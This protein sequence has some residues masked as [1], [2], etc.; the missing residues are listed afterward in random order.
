MSALRAGRRSAETAAPVSLRAVVLSAAFSC[1]ATAACRSADVRP[2]AGSGDA[3]DAGAV[4]ACA[5]S[6]DAPIRR[7]T[8]WEYEATANAVLGTDERVA[9][10]LPESAGAVF[11]T[12]VEAQVASGV[13]VEGLDAAAERLALAA[14]LGAL[15][16]CGVSDEC[17]PRFVAAVGARAFR[18]SLTAAELE[19]F[20]ALYATLRRDDATDAAYRGVLQALLQ[21]P[22]FVFRPERAASSGLRPLSGAEV[23]TR[24]AFFLWGQ[25][26]DAALLAAAAR[27]ELDDKPGVARWAGLLLDDPRARAQVARF[28]VEWLGVGALAHAAKDDPRFEGLR[29]SL[30]EEVRRFGTW[31]TLDDRHFSELFRARRSFLNA[32]LGALYGL[33]VESDGTFHDT[34]LQ[35]TQRQGVLTLPGVLAAWAKVDQS[36]PVQR[37]RLVRERI[38][39]EVLPSPPPNVVAVLPP[40]TSGTTRQRLAAHVA[41]EACAGCHRLIDPVG[42]LFENYDAVGGYRAVENQLPVDARGEVP[43]HAELTGKY[44]GVLE[45]E[46]ALAG[47]QA[48]RRCL[49]TQWL[50]FARGRQERPDEACLVDEAVAALAPGK[51]DLRAMLVALASSDALRLVQQ[52]AP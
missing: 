43:R 16:P 25:G 13:F 46:D 12:A 32:P 51:D 52:E 2:D 8:P 23:A 50:R 34:S 18:R 24:L 4:Q 14:P 11:S 47:T 7:L 15:S 10:L 48:A 40:P 3:V 22:Q 1:L 30:V 44:T 31:A 6:F 29:A 38:L 5:P 42:F 19:R 33:P 36:S 41:D 17:L 28:H 37:G 27:G 21:A 35:R 20:G 9:G 39:C 45:L 26:P 49:A